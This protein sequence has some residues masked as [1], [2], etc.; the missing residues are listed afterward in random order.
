MYVHLQNARTAKEAWDALQTAFEDKGL[1][2]KIH[3]RRQLHSTTYSTSRNMEDYITKMMQTAQKLNDIGATVDDQDLAIMMLSNLTD[4]FDPLVIALENCGKDLTTDLVKLKLLQ[5]DARRSSQSTSYSEAALAVKSKP[6]QRWR[7]REKEKIMTSKRFQG[8][9]YHCGKEGHK[10]GECRS[11]IKTE[12]QSIK[13]NDSVLF[14]NDTKANYGW[15]IDSGASTHMCSSSDMYDT[16]QTCDAKAVYTADQRGLEAKGQGNIKVMLSLNKNKVET[17]IQDVLHVPQL[18]NNLLSVRQLATRGYTIKFKANR[19]Y[20][21]DSLNRLLATATESN[22]LYQLDTSNDHAQIVSSAPSFDLWHRRFAHLGY[23]TLKLLKDG[24]VRGLVTQG[25]QTSV[26]MHCA[27]GKQHGD[28]FPRR[29]RKRAKDILDLIH[30]D[31]CGPFEVPSLGGAKYFLTFIDDKTRKTHVYFLKRND[32]ITQFF[33]RYKAEVE[34]EQNRT[35][36]KIRTDNGG[37]YV[38][39]AFL[40]VLRTAGIKHQTTIPYTPHQNG[41]AERA[42]RTIVEKTRAMLSDANLP[43]TFWAE[44]V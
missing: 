20:I 23:K 43:K 14:T 21:N 15:Y 10:I 29:S 36:K 42:N 24:M 38:N 32:E 39:Q 12:K 22:G 44:A 9:C 30:S 27:K 3:L 19:C 4:D 5:E 6:Q 34:N 1:V 33:I 41:V 25:E 13:Q 2:R 18:K 8:K 17:E 11:R 16:Y 26:C 7:N 28:P 40:N 31:L 35:I 37:E